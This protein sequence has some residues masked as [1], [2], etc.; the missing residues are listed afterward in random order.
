MRHADAG[1]QAE[2]EERRAVEVQAHV[3]LARQ[4]EE[5]SRNCA[6]LEGALDDA[7]AACSAQQ[8]LVQAG[9]PSRLQPIPSQAFAG[10]PDCQMIPNFIVWCAG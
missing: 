3:R 7:Q 9:P 5:A 6:H 10:L 8:A 1:L 4:Q 2:A